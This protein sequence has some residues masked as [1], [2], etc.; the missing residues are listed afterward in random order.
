MSWGGAN[1]NGNAHAA[2]EASGSS[3]QIPLTCTGHTRPVV[4][5]SF[6]S[7]THTGDFFLI[8]ACKDSIPILRKG[9]TGDW[10]G[11]FQG[12]KGAVWSAKLTRDAGL[13][14][15]GS[16]DF[17]AKV[18]NNVTG[19]T[20]CTFEHKHVVRIVDISDDGRY[21]MTGGM[22]KK[23]RI[24][25]MQASPQTE[26]IRTLEGNGSAVKAGLLDSVHGLVF[27]GDD[28]ELRVW[29]LRQSTQVSSRLFDSELTSLKFSWDKRFI[30]C[31]AGKKVYFYDAL[32]AITDPYIV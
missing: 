28:K 10:V 14:V 31:T 7:Y 32:R 30:I 19:D 18:W 24:F 16:G 27:N 25:D 21:V 17:S 3:R 26:P 15:T 8:S 4:D 6:S 23:I 22:E 12:H 5:L 9:N 11:S 29:D 13:S 2:T 1:P 20:V